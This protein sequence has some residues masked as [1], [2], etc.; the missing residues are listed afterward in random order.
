M[1][2]AEPRRICARYCPRSQPAG[3]KCAWL[4]AVSRSRTPTAFRPRPSRGATS[5][6]RRRPPAAAI[7]RCASRFGFAPDVAAV[8]NV[9][10][11]GRAR[12]GTRGRRAAGLPP[13]RSPAVLSERRS[14]L[15]ARRRHLQRRDGYVGVRMARTRQRMRLWPARSHVR[16]DSN[17]AKP[18]HAPLRRAMRRSR[19][20]TTSPHLRSATASPHRK[21]RSFRPRSRTRHLPRLRHRGRASIACS[22]PDESYRRRARGHWCARSRGFRRRSVR[23]CASRVRDP[24]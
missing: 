15:S 4:R 11:C 19:F 5:T 23:C 7:G 12:R 17:R 20:R 18:S 6:I 24:I 1:P 13:A 14:P 9:L 8:H 16:V 2:K 22:S 21:R 10:D 3:T